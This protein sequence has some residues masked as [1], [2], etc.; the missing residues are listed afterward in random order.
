MKIWFVG[1]DGVWDD[2]EEF[3][4][5]VHVASDSP[6]KAIAVA[7]KHFEAYE[8]EDNAVKSLELTELR[9]SST[10]SIDIVVTDDE[11]FEAAAMEVGKK[12]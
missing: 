11:G 7:R 12:S 3:S 4:E 9:Q 8:L 5:G 6:T 2:G 10:N 1:F